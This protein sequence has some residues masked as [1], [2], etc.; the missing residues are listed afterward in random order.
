M[1]YWY[2]PP[3]EL[4]KKFEDSRCCSRVLANACYPYHKLGKWKSTLQ[5]IYF[6]KSTPD[7]CFVLVTVC[8]YSS[9]VSSTLRYVLLV[10]FVSQNPFPVSIFWRAV[11]SSSS[12]CGSP[13]GLGWPFRFSGGSVTPIRVLPMRSFPSLNSIILCSREFEG[14]TH[15]LWKAFSSRLVHVSDVTVGEWLPVVLRC[16]A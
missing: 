1:T 13:R 10:S 4:S 5:I 15:K 9:V 3:T 8:G 16:S 11:Q 12:K 2:E 6:F 7:S 14:P